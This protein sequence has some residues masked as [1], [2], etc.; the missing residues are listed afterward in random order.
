[1]TPDPAAALRGD[2]PAWRAY[3]EPWYAPYALIA[4]TAVG[5]APILIPLIVIQHGTPA[6]V[7]LAMAAFNFGN[8][9]APLW[10]L[11]A[12]RYRVH[13]VL[14]AGA[15]AVTGGAVG[16]VAVVPNLG[17]RVALALLAGC[18]TAAASTAAYLM[19]VDAHPRAEWP[20]RIGAVQLWYCAGQVA[21]LALAGATSRLDLRAGLL[22]DGALTAAAAVPAILT[23]RTP[24]RPVLAHGP[25][26]PSE[27]AALALHAAHVEHGPGRMLHYLRRRRPLRVL[28]RAVASPFGI[29][30]VP[31]FLASAGASALFTVYPVLMART[32]GVG[33]GPSSE[34]YAAAVGASLFLFG[35]A[36]AWSAQLG[37]DRVVRL[38]FALRVIS[39]SAMVVAAGLPIPGRGA[40][41][42]VAFGVCV[43]AWTPIS[44]GGT[45]LAAR[46]SPVG[47]GE[48]LGLFAATSAVASVLGAMLGGWTAARWGYPAVAGLGVA[49]IACA[50]AAG[51]ADPER[52]AAPVAGA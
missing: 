34:G 35:P 42:E 13:R 37:A 16:A 24:P 21:G 44:V 47:E 50:L 2:R 18:G 20:R 48:G 38:G 31:W 46:R 32:F 29:F 3:V 22:I 12:D 17:G 1:M 8:I 30:L 6:A 25:H 39:L 28:G 36:G 10:G 23:A 33:P 19:V 27:A 52:R 14:F 43:L 40:L 51:A 9:A 49:C 15:A 11:L 5:G 26:P 45:I 41:A 4:V 7:G